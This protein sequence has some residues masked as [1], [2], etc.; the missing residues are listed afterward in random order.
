MINGVT[1]C[2]VAYY[3]RL[4]AMGVWVAGSGRSWYTLLHGGVGVS[5]VVDADGAPAP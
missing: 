3:P 2:M 1:V 5:M 4:V